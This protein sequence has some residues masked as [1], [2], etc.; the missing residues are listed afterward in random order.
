MAVLASFAP[1]KGS[2]AGR[3]SCGVADSFDSGADVRRAAGGQLRACSEDRTKP[4]WGVRVLGRDSRRPIRLQSD[5][6]PPGA[7]GNS[8][9][10]R[11]RWQFSISRQSV[12]WS[13]SSA[14]RGKAP[15]APREAAVLPGRPAAE[16]EREPA[17]G[18]PPLRSS[19]RPVPQNEGAPEL[20]RRCPVGRSSRHAASVLL[21]GSLA[22]ASPRL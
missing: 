18:R 1:C 13:A 19:R 22:W 4:G 12:L 5:P 6:R 8:S 9:V 10:P 11:P 17:S 20:S 7:V 3:R 14:G 15:F 2:V 21:I 16:T